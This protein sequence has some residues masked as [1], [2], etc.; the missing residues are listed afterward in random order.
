MSLCLH[1]SHAGHLLS[2]LSYYEIVRP[3]R[4]TNSGD[5]S[6][7]DLS[8]TKEESQD[9]L[10]TEDLTGIHEDGYISRFARSPSNDKPQLK[11]RPNRNFHFRV[12]AFGVNLMLTVTRNRHLV[13]PRLKVERFNEDGTIDNVSQDTLC[14]YAGTVARK[15][16]SSVA[17]SNCNGLVRCC[18]KF[19]R[20]CVYFVSVHCK[21]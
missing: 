2:K 8:T 11:Y 9:I 4:S 16:N 1:C 18:K 19:K 17:I 14:F 13:S 7:N 3:F 12:D 20:Y 5:F 10:N 6:S 21:D 15:P